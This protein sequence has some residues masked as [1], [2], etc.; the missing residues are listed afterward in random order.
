MCSWC[1]I[2]HSI[3]G[4]VLM[5][6]LS[7]LSPGYAVFRRTAIYVTSEALCDQWTAIW[8]YQHTDDHLLSMVQDDRFSLDFFKYVCGFCH[9]VFIVVCLCFLVGVCIF[10]VFN[11]FISE[12]FFFVNFVFTS[13]QFFLFLLYSVC[14]SVFFLLFFCGIYIFLFNL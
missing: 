8:P 4:L 6:V 1:H 2:N 12:V 11:L 3:T 10:G 7:A 9:L 14:F 13:L 5:L